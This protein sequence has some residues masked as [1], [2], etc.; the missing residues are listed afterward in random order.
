ME[1]LFTISM[2]HLFHLP[3]TTVRNIINL[4]SPK[5]KDGKYTFYQQVF[6]LKKLMK[7]ILHFTIWPFIQIGPGGL[8]APPV[9]FTSLAG[10]G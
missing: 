3:V 2:L 6:K 4:S 10:H 8:L 5:C 7:S 9:A 1:L